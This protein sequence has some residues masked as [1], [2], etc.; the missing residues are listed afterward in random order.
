MKS[1]QGF[2]MMA[3]QAFNRVVKS[4]L[5]TLVTYRRKWIVYLDRP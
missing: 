2:S 4:S 1:N 5:W 3:I